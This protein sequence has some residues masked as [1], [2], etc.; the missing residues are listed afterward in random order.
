MK[1]TVLDDY[2][3]TLRT[4]DCYA[5]LADHDVTVW[6]D[7]VQDVE[8]LADRLHDTEAL[9]LIRERTQIRAELLE[10]LA[11]LRLISLRSAYPHVDVD[12]CTRLGITVSSD[13][14]T[15]SPSYATAELTW[16]LVLAGVRH[17]PQQVAALRAGE[18]QTDVGRTLRLKTLGIFGYGRIGQVV[19]GYGRAFGMDVLVW[20]RPESRARARA[21]GHRVAETQEELF[22]TSDVVTLH[23]RL[24]DDTRHIVTPTDLAQM[25]PTALLVNTSRAGLVQDG[26][27]AAALQAGRP[28]LAAVDVYDTEPVV[29]DQEPLL[30]LGNVIC[31]PHIGYV[32]VE[33]WEIQFT[34]VF[35][36]VS[37][38]DA[39]TPLNVVNPSV[40]RRPRLEP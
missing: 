21:D 30:A 13:L 32:T 16:G 40:V 31:T 14:H 24:V 29:R 37:A 15:G 1:V 25:K 10:R 11:R 5:E 34:D 18:W 9:V 4:L 17:V 39:G 36:Q 33:E 23:L 6:T 20:G 7:H 12:T 28:G 8:R 35:R 22:A 26:A 27:L 38:F 3:D 2:L 19:A